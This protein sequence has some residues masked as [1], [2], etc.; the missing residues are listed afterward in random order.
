MREGADPS[1]LIAAAKRYRDDPQVIRGFGKH[2]ATWLNAKCW[3]DEPTPEPD[4]ARPPG[5][6]INRRQ[7]ETDE[8]F[9]RAAQRLAAREA[10]GY[11]PA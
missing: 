10:R 7:Q 4:A 8:Q 3:L 6:V 9:A 1:V 5:M 2:P 11:D